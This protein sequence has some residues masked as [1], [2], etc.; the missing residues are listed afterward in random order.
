MLRDRIKLIA[1]CGGIAVAYL[2]VLAL[3]FYPVLDA[4]HAL[5]G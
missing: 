4:A 1:E 5:G 3:L 2:A